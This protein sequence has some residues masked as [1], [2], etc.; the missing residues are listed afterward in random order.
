MLMNIM[1]LKIIQLQC[2]LTTGD[3]SISVVAPI[4]YKEKLGKYYLDVLFT[5][6]FVDTYEGKNCI[7][8]VLNNKSTRSICSSNSSLF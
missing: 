3:S 8:K 2:L 4:V 6:S 1:Q 5:D 7:V